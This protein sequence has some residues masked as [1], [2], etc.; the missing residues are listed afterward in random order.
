MLSIVSHQGNANQYTDITMP[1]IK[2]ERTIA[3]V[4][5]HVEKRNTYILLL[6]KEL[7]GFLKTLNIHLSSNST[8]RYFPK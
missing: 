4:D 6:C 1:T 5:E 8:L 7:S 3:S 2:T